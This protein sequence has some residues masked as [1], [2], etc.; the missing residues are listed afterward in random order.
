MTL[1]VKIGLS[2]RAANWPSLKLKTRLWL[3]QYY[4]QLVIA[5]PIFGET[6]ENDIL[7]KK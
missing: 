3:A 6:C 4:Q 1:N 7:S 5:H 2:F